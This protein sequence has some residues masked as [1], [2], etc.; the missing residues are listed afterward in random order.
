MLMCDLY[1]CET[2]PNSSQA[3]KSAG[4]FGKKCLSILLHGRWYMYRYDEI[5]DAVSLVSMIGAMCE[6]T[7]FELSPSLGL[8]D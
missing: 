2:F 7:V 4:I 3:R 6:R 1:G 5:M 8:H